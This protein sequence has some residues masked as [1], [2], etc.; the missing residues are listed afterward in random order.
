ML[1][2]P[3]AADGSNQRLLVDAAFTAHP[4]QLKLPE[5]IGSMRVPY[6]LAVG[7]K[8]FQLSMDAVRQVQVECG[9]LDV[10]TEVVIY[11]GAKHGF[12]IRGDPGDERQKTQGLEATEQAVNWFTRHLTRE[13]SSSP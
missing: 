2:S 10:P 11:D 13:K 7:S 3:T 8:D 5:D 12:A 4:S 9:K 6:S 1:C